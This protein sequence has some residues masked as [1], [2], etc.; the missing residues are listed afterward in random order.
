M[1]EIITFLLGYLLTVELDSRQGMGC[2]CNQL[3]YGLVI[4]D[5]TISL[6]TNHFLL[7]MHKPNRKVDTNDTLCAARYH[8]NSVMYIGEMP[9]IKTSS[10]MFMYLL[11]LKYC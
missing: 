8:F 5:T 3:D 9:I 10:I 11:Y 7:N 2:Y 1:K 6:S 4:Q